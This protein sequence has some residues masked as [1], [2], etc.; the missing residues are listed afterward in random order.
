MLKE[1]V[2]PLVEE[3]F[4]TQQVSAYFFINY[5]ERGP[6]LRLRLKHDKN[7]SIYPYVSSILS[8]YMHKNPSNINSYR[9]SDWFPNDTIHFIDYEPEIHRYGG[10][11]AISVAEKQFMN[12]TKV[13]FAHIKDNLLI[14]YNNALNA[15]IR[16]HI[17]SAFYYCNENIEDA[18]N[19]FYNVFVGRSIVQ[20]EPFIKFNS[21]D[22]HIYNV[23]FRQ[24]KENII[25]LVKYIWENLEKA[26]II[27]DNIQYWLLA[28]KEICNDLTKIQKQNKLVVP[29]MYECFPLWS[30]FQSYIHMTNNRLGLSPI[31]EG[32]IAYFLMESLKTL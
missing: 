18:V 25:P 30:I 7:D 23:Y 11:A 26:E 28:E 24:Q 4:N 3:L 31:D 1:C 20:Y 10:N 15:A 27:D 5:G 12:S 9:E 17:A 14:S 16:L 21:K 13:V 8:D 6:H 29:Y 19:F 2:I 22:E 32:L